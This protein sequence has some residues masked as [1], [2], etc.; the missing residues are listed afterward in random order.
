MTKRKALSKE[1]LKK[2]KGGTPEGIDIVSGGSHAARD[3]LNAIKN[4]F[5]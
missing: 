3:I 1:E 4:Y 5:K 2:I